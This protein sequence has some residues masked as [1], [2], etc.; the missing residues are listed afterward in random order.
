MLEQ[1]G[2][3]TGSGIVHVARRVLGVVD[4]PGSGRWAVAS[5]INSAGTGLLLP[6][7]VL[8]FTIHVGLSPASVGL[9]LTIGGLIA[10]AFVPVGGIVID[11]FGSKPVL[12]GCWGWA[13]AAYAGY[14][15]VGSWGEF[16][17]VV[18]AAEIAA[19]VSSTAGKSLLAELATG[20]DRLR[21]LASQRSLGNLGY[22]VGGVLATAALAIGGV[23]YDGVVYGDA[24]TFVVAIVL[25]CGV[26]VPSGRALAGERRGTAGGLRLV[27]ADRRYLALSALDFLT[28]FQ[29]GALAVA[30]P[31]WV[32]LHTQAPRALAG[33]LFT[34]NTAVVVLFQVRATAGVSSIADV[35]RTYRR[36]A[37]VM[38]G[39]A[40]AYLSAHYVGEA[41]A[42]T[43]LVVA[44]VL[45][46]A[47]EMFVSAGEWTASV[48]LADDAHRGI[49]LSIY[50]LGYSVQDALA[51][52]IVTT[53]LAIGTVWLWP[54]LA[55]AVC[56]G[57]LASAVIAGRVR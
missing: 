8:Y 46:T 6:L 39:C 51:P 27:L 33:I 1:Q 16:L 12:L 43:L 35:P 7:S 41:A 52:L 37:V 18:T 42:V 15:L 44:L 20:A 17:V 38:V 23:A 32:V 28:T 10:L 48:E 49:Y 24:L 14:G 31:L 5:L 3:V 13:A 21:L 25:V 50:R 34:I 55:L 26:P 30:L 56:S 45:H 36:G 11:R 4:F 19:A 53:L 2:W 57:A 54:V 47:T 9:G 29:D 40:A 22:G